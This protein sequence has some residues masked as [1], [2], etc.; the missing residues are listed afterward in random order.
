MYQLI[1][2]LLFRMDP[3]QVHQYTLALVKLAGD[4]APANALLCRIFEIPDS[5]LE[6]EAFG[7]KFKNPVGLAAGYDKDGRAVRG[8]SCLGFGHVEVG[9]LTPRPQR[10]NPLPR[11]HRVPEAEA[12]INSMG[13]PNV[14]V[15]ALDVHRNGAK[16]GINIGKGKETPLKE[17]AEEYVELLRRVQPQADY[18]ALNISSPNTL[19]LRRLQSRA[20]IEELLRAVA[21]ERNRLAPRRPVLVKIAP[22]LCEAEI[23]D[24]LAAVLHSGI[25][26]VIATNTTVRREGLP[27]SARG[28]AAG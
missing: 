16:V 14:G 22:D 20:F 21:A 18:V 19:G 11:I 6:V 5:R 28:Q 17:A 24:V 3:E 25:D 13:F 27:E 23:D 8:L 9:T 2:P 15:E 7:L 10:G 1:R 12:L 26:G 4:F